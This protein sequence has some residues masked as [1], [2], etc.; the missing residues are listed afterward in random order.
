MTAASQLGHNGG[1]PIGATARKRGRPSLYTPE[2][3]DI[4]C[5]RLME[6]E[7]LKSICCPTQ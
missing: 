6:I 7:S 2:L 5:H 3:A 1:P 4:I